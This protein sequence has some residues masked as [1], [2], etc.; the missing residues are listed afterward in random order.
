MLT[1]KDKHPRQSQPAEG[2]QPAAGKKKK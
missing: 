1:E 2:T